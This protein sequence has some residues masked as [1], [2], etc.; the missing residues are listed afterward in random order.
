MLLSSKALIQ[1]EKED[2]DK[3]KKYLKTRK[4]P[5]Q[6]KSAATTELLLDKPTT[7]SNN[8]Y[9]QP[10]AIESENS[11]LH[12]SEGVQEFKDRM[13]NRIQLLNRVN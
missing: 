12:N 6:T 3:K 4:T 8:F 13:K 2:L 11:T 10:L 1:Q 9:V 5:N 7:V